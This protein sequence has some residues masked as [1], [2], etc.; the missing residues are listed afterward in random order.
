MNYQLRLTKTEM[1]ALRKKSVEINNVRMKNGLRLL[2]DPKLLHKILEKSIP[3]AKAA[4]DG[5]IWIE[6]EEP[7]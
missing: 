7:A 5:E 2:D 6:A 3:Y 1:E 4:P